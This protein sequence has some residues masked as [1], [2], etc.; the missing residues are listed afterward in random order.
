[1][2]DL[3]KSF[4]EQAEE[5][6]LSEGDYLKTCNALKK[7]FEMVKTTDG[8]EKPFDVEFKLEF[9]CKF[10][11]SFFLN[12]TKGIRV[13]GP[14]ANKVIYTLRVTKDCT[15]IKEQVNVTCN[16]GKMIAMIKNT[17]YSYMFD[18]FTITNSI[19]CIE[20]NVKKVLETL[21]D[22]YNHLNNLR[23]DDDTEIVSKDE[24]YFFIIDIF[25]RCYEERYDN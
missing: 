5:A 7:T 6:G 16:L 17:C 20:Y 21:N 23:D 4:M 13:S 19:C 22:K 1:M 18:T 24:H 11:Y 3:L 15:I 9:K 25:H 8:A 2:D 14:F 10:G 12:V